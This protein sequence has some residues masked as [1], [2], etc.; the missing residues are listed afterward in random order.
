MMYYPASDDEIEAIF[1]KRLNRMIPTR[2]EQ[3]KFK[4][5][6][7]LFVGRE[8][9]RL[10][11]AMRESTGSSVVQIRVTLLCLIRLRTLMEGWASF[12]LQSFQTSSAVFL[13]S[14]P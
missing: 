12:S 11:W 5:A 4:T 1:L 8:Y 3:L 14:T 2:E 7:M 13:F 10:D 6:F 9:H